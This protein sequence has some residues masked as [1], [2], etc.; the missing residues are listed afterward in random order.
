MTTT[1]QIEATQIVDSEIDSLAEVAD[2]LPSESPL[3]NLLQAVVDA[4]RRGA[5]VTT[6]A[7]DGEL[8]PNQAAKALGMSRPHLLKFIRAG[9]LK[10]RYVGSHQRIAYADFM[11]FKQRHE[12]ASKDVAIALAT[13]RGAGRQISLTDD[14]MA[15]LDDL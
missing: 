9:A 10:A 2:R 7:Q 3:R 1:V 11:D 13:S 5:G 15:E 4:G 12:D 14:E 8:T 6:M